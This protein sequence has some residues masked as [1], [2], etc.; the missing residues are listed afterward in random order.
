MSVHSGRDAWILSIWG[1]LLFG[2]GKKKDACHS[3]VYALSQNR[4]GLGRQRR[5]PETQGA[6]LEGRGRRG[7]VRWNRPSTSWP[8]PDTHQGGASS[9]L[10]LGRKGAGPLGRKLRCIVG[11][12]GAS[13]SNLNESGAPLRGRVRLPAL[14]SGPLAPERSARWRCAA[15]TWLTT[16]S[17]RDG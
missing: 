2:W 4:L 5:E 15:P 14:G 7:G 3:L 13:E 6:G 1:F 17:R 12:P 9:S 16:R 10:D 8:L 11:S